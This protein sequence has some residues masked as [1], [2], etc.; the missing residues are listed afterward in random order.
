LSRKSSKYEARTLLTAIVLCI[1]AGAGLWFLFY[2]HP[3][4]SGIESIVKQQFALNLH[5]T[6][7]WST[8]VITPLASVRITG[9]RFIS[10]DNDTLA[11][12]G[13]TEGRF[14]V[15]P[16]LWRHVSIPSL[17]LRDVEADYKTKPYANLGALF[18]PRLQQHGP[19][20]S[21]EIGR[22]TIDSGRVTIR[23]STSKVTVRLRGI[24]ARG[25][26]SRSTDLLLR[27]AG[28]GGDLRVKDRNFALDSFRLSL[29]TDIQQ[30]FLDN[31]A[32]VV[33]RHLDLTGAFCF[34]YDTLREFSAKL[35]AVADS[36]FF[37]S[38]D[39][40]RWGIGRLSRCSGTVAATGAMK[41]PRLNVSLDVRKAVFRTVAIDSLSLAL[42]R[43][44][45]GTIH[46]RADAGGSGTKGAVTISAIIPGFIANPSNA[47]YQVKGRVGITDIL[48]LLP[49]SAKHSA[50]SLLRRVPLD[51][52]F[53]ASGPALKEMPDQVRATCSI[54]SALTAQGKPVP[55]VTFYLQ[56][57]RGALAISGI[58]RG[59]FQ[60]AGH[61]TYKD[62]ILDLDASLRIDSLRALSGLL[63]D[64][65]DGSLI[66][67]ARFRHSPGVNRGT[68]NASASELSWRGLIADTAVISLSYDGKAF[69][70]AHA[71]GMVAG[72]VR[73]ALTVMGI[74][75][76]DG[77][78]R[79]TISARG[80]IVA[81][82]VEGEFSI[83]AL[84]AGKSRTAIADSITGIIALRDSVLTA[85][86]MAFVKDS[87]MAKGM[88]AYNL[89][90]REV[91][92]A[93]KFLLGAGARIPAG[94][95]SL[96][97]SMRGDSIGESVLAIDSFPVKALRIWIASIPSTRVLCSARASLA[98]SA[99]NPRGE[100]VVI[101]TD[102]SLLRRPLAT[103]RATL[104]DHTVA[105]RCALSATDSGTPLVVE[106]KA[107]LTSSWVLDTA[108]LTPAVVRISAKR[109]DLFPWARLANAGVDAAGSLN[110]DVTL[111]MRKNAWSANGMASISS[112]RFA[113]PAKN[114]AIDGVNLMMK[115]RGGA[116][117]IADISS[118][119]ISLE[120]GVFTFGIA[121][122]E[123][124]AIRG[125]LTS[126]M[127]TI[128][129]AWV[130]TAQGM[131]RA[132]GTVPLINGERIP[133]APD[134]HL[135]L[136]M[137]EFNIA[138]VNQIIQGWRFTSGTA[139]GDVLI[140][141]TAAGLRANGLMRGK[142]MAIE[143]D[144]FTPSMGPFD[145]TVRLQGDSL[146]IDRLAGSWGGGAITGNGFLQWT[147]RDFVQ[148]R[149]QASAHGLSLWYAEEN[150]IRVDT[151][152]IILERSLGR[153]RIG[154]S[155]LLGESRL[156]QTVAI[157]PPDLA[158][159]SSS[160]ET[161][162]KDVALDVTV[163]AP[164]NLYAD[165]IIAQILTGP[166]SRLQATCGGALA[167]GGTTAHPSFTGE[168]TVIDGTVM[169]LDRLFHITRGMV[170][171]PGGTEINPSV[172]LTAVTSIHEAQ[173]GEFSR[174]DSISIT[175]GITGELVNPVLSLQS[176]P[177]VYSE[178]EIISLLTFG[179][180]SLN[181]SG[182][183]MLGNRASSILSQ[184]VSFYASAQ[185]R[186]LLG[187][188][189]VTVTG[190]ILQA[191]TSGEK[192]TVT[193][194]KRIGNAVTVTYKGLVS[195]A[196]DQSAMVSW[197][198]LP[199]LFL[200][201]ESDIGGNA[202]I[203]IKVKVKK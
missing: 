101:V 87:L 49:R 24:T 3:W 106:G 170:H 55:P 175:L 6:V 39:V 189:Q 165:V 35:S 94:A 167:I 75:N 134:F 108:G 114:V 50:G 79:A 131:L 105:A 176:A 96:N 14:N 41:S 61:G 59:G 54:P 138:I 91:T 172:S 60:I 197:K 63:R 185:A 18:T 82:L 38:F 51:L 45:D 159:L 71:Y 76:I 130:R 44:P 149:L 37:E 145:A 178:A 57:D 112:G 22:I 103:A 174:G 153:W 80:P 11:R 81:P 152:Q 132:R 168:V 160:S 182:T 184:T 158:T 23:D 88:V 67:M 28:P 115:P 8:L 135:S 100:A 163:K 19:A 193:V 43:N 190:D 10:L 97:V 7:T 15:V 90:G 144:D 143:V 78:I 128:N 69:T 194:S 9:I 17:S 119:E 198:I 180:A 121:S 46:C 68:V 129:E 150:N 161:M 164:Q 173:G 36:A 92:G 99:A 177:I 169:Y 127:M 74:D 126:K 72:P 156:V 195:S 202:G 98:G 192:T 191:D 179:E 117:T 25:N 196:K 151:A 47:S 157:N 104:F 110:A 111:N 85:R 154:G 147:S 140:A 29:R 148:G 13:R 155:V 120:T 31:F 200:D 56:Y 166:I 16:L 124:V 34:P 133:L 141:G 162:A 199:F 183:G 142:A 84:S 201:G 187:L 62:R 181:N 146:V 102:T 33:D 52:D 122:G 66:A 53:S 137:K 26:L 12:I 48:G 77:I 86:D 113:W 70:I 125:Q 188:D 2:I 116:G 58:S 64:E 107:R 136:S 40:A 203:D 5:G 4:Q 83:T 21:V 171:F 1:I 42:E 118:A 73:N 123:A 93:W 27:F 20:W 139:D 32:V 30:C 95:C 109:L 186:K 89:P 65:V